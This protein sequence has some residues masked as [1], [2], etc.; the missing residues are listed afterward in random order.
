LKKLML[1]TDTIQ[2]MGRG[3]NVDFTI[4][5]TVPFEI[6]AKNLRDY[7][8]ECRGLYSKGTV[9][10][11]VGRRILVA[12]Q[13][14][15]IKNI[16]D[17]ET[18]LT[19][20]RYWCAPEIL[21]EALARDGGY[22]TPTLSPGQVVPSVSN[23]L[24][25]IVESEESK[26][27]N[28]AAFRA[29]VAA[30]ETIRFNPAHAVVQ[31]EGHQLALAIFGPEEDVCDLAQNSRAEADLPE[32]VVSLA[33]APDSPA[34]ENK[35]QTLVEETPAPSSS[36]DLHFAA[37]ELEPDFEAFVGPIQPAGNSTVE[38]PVPGFSESRP[39]EEPVLP[40]PTRGDVSFGPHRG[41]EALIIKTTCRS[42]EV[43]RYPGDVV[44]LAD[45]NPGAEI[46][47]GGDI[48]VLGALRGMARAG[49]EGDLKSTIIAMNLE[50]HRLQIGPHIGEAPQ[51]VR[52]PRL[53]QHQQPA[54]PQIAYLRRS[55]IFVAPFLRR[56][57]DYQGGILYEG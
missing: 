3:T 10:V 52:R 40:P 31:Q 48:V 12:E 6:A 26:E 35:D 21:E 32:P 49:A 9:S 27:S 30:A 45:V 47:A 11:N 19:V 38:E 54:K 53:N 56:N 4:D 44:V 7:L 36:L 16:L 41:K 55:S 1:E 14:S 2:V 15:G 28:P 51:N 17:K 23:P 50:S 57:E 20:S 18:G 37:A 43:I 46:I 39:A 22:K 24:K 33:A 5:D 29:G 13:L 42:G 8:S 25:K 34:P